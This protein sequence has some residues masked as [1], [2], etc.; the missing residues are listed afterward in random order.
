MSLPR[1]RGSYTDCYDIL[2][3]AIADGKGVRIPAKN[4][5]S[6]VQLRMRLH[7]ARVLDRELNKER[8]EEGHF[9]HG[10]SDY[11]KLIVK[12][13]E[14]AERHVFLYIEHASLA[15]G[16]I[17]GLSEITPEETTV[18]LPPSAPQYPMLPAPPPQTVRVEGLQT[19]L[20]TRRRI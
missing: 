14:N 6:A 17:E 20:V 10:A 3:Q 5:D 2:D 18:A 16:K 15:W 13:R 12:L 1:S 9:M 11:D 19:G 4:Y 7:M 8:Y